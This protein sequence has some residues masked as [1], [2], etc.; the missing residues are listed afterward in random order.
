MK[1]IKLTIIFLLLS[2]TG[3]SQVRFLDMEYFNFS[4]SIDPTATIKESSP[5]LVAE[6]ELVSYWG[7]VKA[8][9]QI[10][11]GLEGGYV[12]FGGAMG[13][14]ITFDRWNT[15]RAYSGIRLGTIRRGGY[16]YP[17][18]GFEGGVD[19]NINDKFF[20]GYRGT[21]DWREDFLFSGA[22]PAYRLSSYLRA[23]IKW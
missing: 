11:P 7:Y 17:L 3:I 16:S 1:T 12:D 9:A 5:N 23:G 2:L 19:W 4:A 20:I 14:N 8:T 6:L 15:F 21:A 13:V 22:D 18:F 10:L